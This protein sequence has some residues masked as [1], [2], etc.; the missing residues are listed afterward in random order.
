M[1]LFNKFKENSQHKL[2]WN[3]N[4]T[5][6]YATVPAVGLYYLLMH[7]EEVAANRAS[8]YLAV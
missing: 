7:V 3:Y 4:Q 6:I 2:L 1:M 5:W 8:V